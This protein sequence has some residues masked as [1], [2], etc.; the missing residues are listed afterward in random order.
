MQGDQE[1]PYMRGVRTVLSAVFGNFRAECFGGSG[2]RVQ[3][4][5]EMIAGINRLYLRALA[6]VGFHYFLWACPVLKGDEPA[7]DA[8]RAFI[9]AGQGDWRE[10]VQIDA[11]QFHPALRDGGVPVHTSH[12]FY[13]ALTAKAATAHVQFFVDRHGPPPPPSRIRLATNPLLIEGKAFACH[14]ARYFNKDACQSDGHD[15]ELV[16]IDVWE[17]RL[18]TPRSG[19]IAL[20]E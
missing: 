19:D 9:S 6:K 12:L 18:I 8:L 7:L 14:Q 3:H 16:A 10:F 20:A 15:G 1:T 13:A 4:R 2:E 5:L 11:P 17:R